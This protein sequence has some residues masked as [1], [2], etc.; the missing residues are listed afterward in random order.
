[1]EP[2]IAPAH[3]RHVFSEETAPTGTLESFNPATGELVGTVPTIAPDQVPAVVAEIEKV[4]KFWAEMSFEDRGRY[5]RRAA[6]VLLER[7]D[8]IA[9]LITA[10]QGKVRTEAFGME[11]M[12]SVDGIVWN[13]ENAGEYLSDD[14][15]HVS[16]ALYKTHKMRFH[17][18]PLGVVGVISPW[19]YPMLLA[20]HEISMVLMAGNGVIFKPASLTCLI[21]QMIQEVFDEAGLPEG[22]LRTVHGGGSVGQAMVDCP[23]VKK[24]FFTGSVPVGRAI[25]QDC[26]KQLKPISL[27]LGGKDPMIVLSDANVENAAIGAQWGGFANMGQTCAG[28]ERVYV[29]HDVAPQFIDKVVEK[30]NAMPLGDPNEWSTEITAMTDPNQYAIV[31]ELVE[32]AVAHGATLLC[33]GPIEQGDMPDGLKSDYYFAPTVLTGVNHGMRIMK[34]EIFGPVLPIITVDS[35]DEAIQL[36]NDSNFGLGA[37]VWTSDADKGQAIAERIES[38]NVWI[39]DHMY[40]AG[41]G[42]CAWGGVKES[43]VGRSHGPIG[44]MEAVEVKTIAATPSRETTAGAHPYGNTVGPAVR[45]MLDLVYGKGKDRFRTLKEGVPAMTR[46]SGRAVGNLRNK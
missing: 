39:N 9:K 14:K 24:I 8:E 37:S 30:A 25:A 26:A 2:T 15:I 36:S 33:G 38:G 40:T 13:S 31:K 11:I 20:M 29:M 19:N 23:K 41:L 45:T 7:K 3:P 46:F 43:G 5:I 32:D 4:Q 35:E 18:E 21:G 27:E 10:E 34:E 6:D 12:A 42:Q 16:Q 17:Y 44:F 22:L 28:I 1:M